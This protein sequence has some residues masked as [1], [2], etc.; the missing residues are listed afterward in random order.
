MVQLS[1]GQE[2]VF[3][4]SRLLHSVACTFSWQLQQRPASLQFMPSSGS[5]TVRGAFASIQEQRSRGER[6]A[7]LGDEIWGRKLTAVDQ[8]KVD[9][10]PIPSHL[11]QCA[12]RPQAIMHS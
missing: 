6:G 7:C 4:S 9:R 2:N 11:H 5:L 3:T 1:L 8:S 12:G 10:V